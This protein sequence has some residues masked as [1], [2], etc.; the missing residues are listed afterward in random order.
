M[1]DL[2]ETQNHPDKQFFEQLDDVPAGMLHLEGASLHAQPMAASRGEGTNSL[3]IF[4]KSDSELVQ[5]IRKGHATAHYSVVGKNHDFHAC[6]MGHIHETQ[7]K[8]KIDAFWNPVVAAWYEEG[9]EDPLLVLL[10]LDL[11]TAEVWGSTGSSVKFGWE[12][13]KA[14][15]IDDKTPDVGVHTSVKFR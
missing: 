1:V 7:D 11:E 9:K 15:L 3:F 10:Q 2:N 8:S 4:A 12:I 6:A 14:N 13:A 5:E